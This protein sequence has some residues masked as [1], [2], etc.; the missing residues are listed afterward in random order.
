[1]TNLRSEEDGFGCA[2][3]WA[4]PLKPLVKL[5][6]KTRRS[7]LMLRKLDKAL[8]EN[9]PL[10]PVKS[11]GCHRLWS[12]MI[13]VLGI[14][15]PMLMCF[16]KRPPMGFSMLYWRDQGHELVV[17]RGV[18][19]LYCGWLFEASSMRASTRLTLAIAAVSDHVTT[20]YSS[21]PL[22]C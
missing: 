20:R 12:S 2:F 7:F 10:W 5:G 8:R 17:N 4:G 13:E 21:H 3:T 14:S 19:K 15:A 9:I 1:M 11:P 22:H 16:E 6:F 18:G